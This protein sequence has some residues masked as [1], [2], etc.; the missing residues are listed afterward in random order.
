[1]TRPQHD[2]QRN[3]VLNLGPVRFIVIPLHEDHWI[4]F[5][6]ILVVLLL[7]KIVVNRMQLRREVLL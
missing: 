6:I 1:M 7:W 2:N 4:K 3:N 5:L